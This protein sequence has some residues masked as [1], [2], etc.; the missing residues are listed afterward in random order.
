MIPDDPVTPMA[1][2]KKRGFTAAANAGPRI[3]TRPERARTGQ[4]VDF[5]APESWVRL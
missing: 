1:K 5:R 4:S 2:L 3:S